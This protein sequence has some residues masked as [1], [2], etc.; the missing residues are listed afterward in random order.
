MFCQLLVLMSRHLCL[1]LIEKLKRIK[2]CTHLFRFRILSKCSVNYVSKCMP[3][4]SRWTLLP[5]MVD[6]RTAR[7]GVVSLPDN[8]LIVAGGADDEYLCTVE[9]LPTPRDDTEPMKW[10][11][12][13]PMNRP[14]AYFG[15]SFCRRRIFAVG[16]QESGSPS[17][18]STASVEM[19]HFPSEYSDGD[20]FGDIGQWTLINE[21]VRPSVVCSLL[22]NPAQ[23]GKFIAFGEL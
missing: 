7:P 4:I 3:T 12:M 16:G 17:H 11:S 13:A 9:C 15:L 20:D 8:T 6:C 23:D 22:R 10:R 19:F 21:M 18:K 14:R 1:T 2:K 5:S